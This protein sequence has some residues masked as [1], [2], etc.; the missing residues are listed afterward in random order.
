[1]DNLMSKIL[2]NLILKKDSN[3]DE[4][5]TGVASILKDIIDAQTIK[6]YD[7]I[8][9]QVIDFLEHILNVKLHKVN[10][11]TRRQK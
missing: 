9:N 3:Y 4:I 10:I 5:A 1:M 8:R 7:N 11:K 6:D 2:G